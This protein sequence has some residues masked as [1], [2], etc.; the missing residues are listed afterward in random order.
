MTE[1][2]MSYN[3]TDGKVVRYSNPAQAELQGISDYIVIEAESFREAKEEM[4]NR[5]KQSNQEED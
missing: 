5:Y 2:T 1:Y 3:R 4:L